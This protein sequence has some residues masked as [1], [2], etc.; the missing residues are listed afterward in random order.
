MS[1]AAK[2]TIVLASASATRAKLLI[3]AGIDVV[4]DPASLDEEEI[5]GA[6]RAEGIDVAG[7]ARAL[8]ES[9]AIRVSERHP[10]ALVIGADQMLEC[11]GAWFDKPRDRQHARADLVALRGKRHELVAAACVARNGALLWHVT[12]RARLTMRTFSDDFLDAYLAAAGGDALNAVGAYRLEG[13]GAQL[14]Q[15]VEGDFFTILGLPLLPLLGYL[16]DQGALAA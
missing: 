15:R 3:E 2:E 7:C 4:V 16:R 8:A 6:F 9:K 13:L 5:R 1:R 12:D 11:D 10:G 14:F